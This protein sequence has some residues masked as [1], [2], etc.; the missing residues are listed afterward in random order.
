MAATASFDERG[1]DD[2]MDSRLTK[3]ELT[4]HWGCF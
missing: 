2:T 4:G 1:S 3:A